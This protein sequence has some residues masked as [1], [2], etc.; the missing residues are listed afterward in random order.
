[1]ESDGKRFTKNV[2]LRT[3]TNL[4][5]V[6]ANILVALFVPKIFGTENYGFYK[7]FT[8]YLTYFGL[9]NI[10]LID[11][12][13][14]KY[15]GS[16]YNKLDKCKFRT[17]VKVLFCFELIVGLAILFISLFAINDQNKYVFVFLGVN[18]LA[19]QFTCFFQQVSEITERFS[20]SSVYDVL[21]SIT[22]I[23]MVVLLYIFK[24]A[25]LRYD[26]IVYLTMYVAFN[27]L[28]LFWYLANYKELLFGKRYKFKDIKGELFELIKMGIPLL[29]ANFAS[30]LILNMDRQ[31][32]DIYFSK[33]EYG[34]YA[35]TYNI[36]TV[37]NAAISSIS[38]VLY[39]ALKRKQRDDFDVTNAYSDANATILLVTFASL[40]SYFPLVKIV[41]WMLP[42][43][44][45]SLIILRIIFP[46][47]AITATIQV[48]KHNFYK[49]V[50][51]NNVFFLF[52][53]VVLALSLGANLIAYHIFKT[54]TSIS[55]ASIITLGLWYIIT[56]TYFVLKYKVKFLS[57][58]IFMLVMMAIYYLSAFL[59]PLWLGFIVY[60]IC[61]I[62]ITLLFY[63]KRIVDIYKKAFKK[64]KIGGTSENN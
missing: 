61:D 38:L 18:M 16:D 48:V 47:V 57:N 31:V 7:T 23:I 41:E 36:L 21:F 22:S 64:E 55:W 5:R 8:L 11:G 28:L 4:I 34:V 35:F 2:I 3:S 32:V 33:S 62:I 50:G 20:K 26:Y 1:M 15:G 13:Y 30:Q 51:K 24:Q 40:A 52:A 37:L 17:F 59:L 9:F 46:S 6:A 29:I 58:L 42:A 14:L 63:K 12:I 43:Y 27:Y 45:G 10:G 54:T 56:E 39:P 44:T 19:V 53:F 25:G 60:L 49:V